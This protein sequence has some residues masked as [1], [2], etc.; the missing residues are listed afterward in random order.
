MT[1]ITPE[2]RGALRA[3]IEQAVTAYRE[4]FPAPY[5]LAPNLALAVRALNALDQAEAERRSRPPGIAGQT[6]PPM[7]QCERVE[8]YRDGF[9]AAEVR[10]ARQEPTDAEVFEAALSL[11][12]AD[13]G[14]SMDDDEDREEVLWLWEDLDPDDSCTRLAVARA[15]LIAARERG[16]SLEDRR[17]E[18]YVQAIVSEWGVMGRFQRWLFWR[19]APLTAIAVRHIARGREEDAR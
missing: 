13:E 1:A 3:D 2:D 8:G 4:V 18:F 12:A 11:F 16:D 6:V 9:E 10:A 7:E 14:W 15:A 5:A 17:E 19:V